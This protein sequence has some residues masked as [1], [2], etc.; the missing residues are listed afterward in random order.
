MLQPAMLEL[1]RPWAPWALRVLPPFPA[2]AHRVLA[3]VGNADVSIRVLADLVKMD[4]SFSA[5][6]LR[7][8]N[9]SLFGVRH[10]VKSG[11]QAILML[12]RRPCSSIRT[13][14]LPPR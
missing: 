13:N 14:S 4:T 10:E 12:G 2:V 11:S 6:L 1:A 9:S 3:L 8:A 5:E 7:F